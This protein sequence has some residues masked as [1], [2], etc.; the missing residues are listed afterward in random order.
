MQKFD[1]R[2]FT[3]KRLK[4]VAKFGGV[5]PEIAHGAGEYGASCPDEKFRCCTQ[6]CRCGGRSILSQRLQCG[7]D[8]KGIVSQKCAMHKDHLIESMKCMQICC[9]AWN[10][11]YCLQCV[12][13][14]GY[15]WL[16]RVGLMTKLISVRHRQT[17]VGQGRVGIGRH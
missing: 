16:R 3:R 6:S 12:Q 17:L 14:G 13:P 10:Q 8:S 11:G 9:T 7:T 5:I 1:L 4:G 2:V 15:H